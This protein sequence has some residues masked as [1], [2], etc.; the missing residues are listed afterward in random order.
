MRDIVDAVDEAI[1]QDISGPVNLGSSVPTSFNELADM[2]CKQANYKP[3]I[4]HIKTAPVGVMF[5]CSNNEKM[6]SFYKPK[7]SLEEGIS[8][9]LNGII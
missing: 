2:V 7:I 5:R 9:A 6:L 4:N 1:K 8:M 3:N